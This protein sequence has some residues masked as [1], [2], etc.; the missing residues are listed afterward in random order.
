MNDDPSASNPADQPQFQDAYPV[1]EGDI[2]QWE[3]TAPPSADWRQRQLIKRRVQK[4]RRVEILDDVIRN[5]DIMIFC[6]L[7]I[8][9]YMEWVVSSCC[10]RYEANRRLP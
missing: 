7:S 9:Y 4:K 2:L 6:E 5:F 3:D 10:H 1:A 8:L